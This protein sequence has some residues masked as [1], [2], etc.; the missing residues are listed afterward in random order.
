MNKKI[1]FLSKT[2]L[3]LINIYIFTFI[4]TLKLDYID[5]VTLNNGN[6]FI[7]HQNGISICDSSF[8]Q[9]IKIFC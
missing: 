9:I 8:S 1:V 4:K 6:I 5:A 2:V 3:F 7:I